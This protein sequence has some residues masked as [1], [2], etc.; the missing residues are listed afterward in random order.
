MYMDVL[1]LVLYYNQ[2]AE[3]APFEQITI[4]IVDIDGNTVPFTLTSYEI[5]EY[6]IEFKFNRKAVSLVNVSLTI[7]Y[8]KSET[9]G[10][11]ISSNRFKK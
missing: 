10:Q 3:I 8:I 1:S 2:K 11:R 6:K 7:P 9:S 4:S 5:T